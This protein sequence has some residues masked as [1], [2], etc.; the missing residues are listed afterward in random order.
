[1]AAD[2][3]AGAA[4]VLSQSE[5]ERLLAQ[6][7]EQENSVT[8]VKEGENKERKDKDIIQPYDFR[9]PVFLSPT[10]LR[11]LRIRH[12]EFIRA[13]A[14]RLSIYL[15]LEFTLQMSK[16]Q[17]IPF[18]KF[19]ES[20]PNPTHL[21]LFKIEPLR[22]IGILEIHPRL[23][24][25]IVDRLL[26]GPAHS[27]AADHDFSEIEMALLDQAVQVIIA[28]WCN[29]WAALQEL[30]P[31]LLGHENNGQFLQTAPH[32]TIMLVL[33]MEAK[34]GDCL[35]QMQIALPCFTLEPLIRKLGQFSEAAVEESTVPTVSLKWNSRFDD[36]S[37]PITAVWDHLEL[38]AREV[39]GLK[40][41]DILP[42]ES[43]SPRQVKLRL[44][45]MS[46][47]QG[48]LGTTNGKWAVAVTE[49]FRNP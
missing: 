10:E 24:L 46:K 47:F 11:R 21:S 7:A 27:I 48:R 5:V 4:D 30:R 49:V 25:T 2:Q 39:A 45:D 19:C 40:E 34:I 9:H 23:G 22:G 20:L 13:L 37:V 35:E 29:H 6:V 18:A 16:L 8:V 44:A 26:G 15:R 28:E 41:G 1:M 17:T 38:T 31:A 43:D 14:A 32:D 3:D 12:E 36:V 33:A 42:L